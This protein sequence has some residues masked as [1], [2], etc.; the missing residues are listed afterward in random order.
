MDKISFDTE[1]SLLYKRAD[2][3][4]LPVE[5][6]IL[7]PRTRRDGNDAFGTTHTVIETLGEFITDNPD[8]N[9]SDLYKILVNVTPSSPEYLRNKLTRRLAQTYLQVRAPKTESYAKGAK[10]WT[11]DEDFINAVQDVVEFYYGM[12]PDELDLP[13]ADDDEDIFTK[14]DG[15]IVF[16]YPPTRDTLSGALL[17][18]KKLLD[19]IKPS[20][21]EMRGTRKIAEKIY[22]Y[23]SSIADQADIPFQRSPIYRKSE[24]VT[25]DVFLIEEDEKVEVDPIDGFLFF[26][27]SHLSENLPYLQY[28][29]M[30]RGSE[31][32]YYKVFRGES[33][34]KEPVY[35]NIIVS[36]D[37]KVSTRDVILMKVWF[38][39]PLSK[40]YEYMHLAPASA[41]VT[42]SLSLRDGTLSFEIPHVKNVENSMEKYIESVESDSEINDYGVRTISE[43]VILDAIYKAFPPGVLLENRREE[44]VKAEIMIYGADVDPTTLAYELS[45]NELFRQFLYIEE[46]THPQSLKTQLSV[47]Y[48]PYPIEEPLVPSAIKD[49]ELVTKRGLSAAIT[50]HYSKVGSAHE[51]YDPE[52][53]VT[54]RIPFLPLTPY[55]SLSIS[56]TSNIK[57]IEEFLSVFTLLLPIYMSNKP[58]IKAFYEDFLTKREYNSLFPKIRVEPKELQKKSVLIDLVDIIPEMA[59]KGY[60]RQAL[61]SH[62]PR[63]IVRDAIEEWV[64]Q[65][66]KYQ[67]KVY[68]KEVLPYPKPKSMGSGSIVLVEYKDDA[69]MARVLKDDG[70]IVWIPFKD[71]DI[72]YEEPS[73]WIVCPNNK[74]PFVGVKKNV[75]EKSMRQFPYMPHCYGLH[76]TSI[77]HKPS[78]SK[79]QK[80]Y[81]GYK[82]KKSK[83]KASNILKTN[84]ILKPGQKGRLASTD[85]EEILNQYPSKV[86]G[87]TFL[88]FG[89]PKSPNSLLHSVLTALV[90]PIYMSYESVEEKEEYVVK[91]RKHIASRVYPGLLKQEL[92]DRSLDEIFDV[93]CN[94]EAFLD[95]SVFYRAL[96]VVFN[97]NIYV[98]GYTSEKVDKKAGEGEM[99]I[100]RSKIYHTQPYRALPTILIVR[101]WGSATDVLEYPQSELIIEEIKGRKAT[102]VFSEEMGKINYDVMQQTASVMMWK[103]DTNNNLQIRKNLYDP[104]IE[105]Y[106][107]PDYNAIIGGN[108]KY[109]IIDDYGKMRGLIFDHDLSQRVTMLIEPSQP[110]NLPLTTK[111]RL[112]SCDDKNDDG[113]MYFPEE[114]EDFPLCDVDVA[115]DIFG[116]PISRTSTS[117]GMTSGLWFGEGVSVYV[118]INPTSEYSD[119]PIGDSNPFESGY[120]ISVMRLDKMKKDLDLVQQVL[121]WV[122]LNY[123]YPLEPSLEDEDKT[124][125]NFVESYLTSDEFDGDSA[126]YYNLDGIGRIFPEVDN[127][128]EALDS[129]EEQIK[130]HFEDNDIT[131]FHPLVSDG[132]MVFYNANFMQKIV[133]WLNEKVQR[134]SGL[135]D[136]KPEVVMKPLTIENYYTSSKDFQLQNFVTVFV[137]KDEFR[138]WLHTI[139]TSNQMHKIYRTITSQL[140]LSTEPFIYQDKKD[141]KIYY[142]QNV[143]GGSKERAMAAS[144]LWESSKRNSG[145]QTPPTNSK[146][147]HVIYGETIN[148]LVVLENNI[149]QNVEVHHK[150]PVIFSSVSKS[151]QY[152]RVLQYNIHET[153]K[154]A[155]MLELY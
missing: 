78:V 115:V 24:S 13:E 63:A 133:R 17:E 85:I 139:S 77:E 52:T 31:K 74:N 12:F 83:S 37:E 41:F 39:H 91:V 14:E 34:D 98:Y 26:N 111:E 9:A 140:A 96:E 128:E 136:T 3:L 15:K 119:I 131:D 124:F 94:G 44:G 99:V 145:W 35:K 51:V 59:K 152:L 100:P 50:Q 27:G 7:R 79:Y 76:G 43:W 154:Y 49:N 125:M 102:M 123:K 143:L 89:I 103:I 55:I 33:V 38:N 93:M 82:S 151:S 2:E 101:N 107:V 65:T 127:V 92:Y 8:V 54:K 22:E 75:S 142:I 97:I 71:V 109:Q 28:N 18:Y 70:E 147:P 132:K 60:T 6:F 16:R 72:D 121:W 104:D 90:D 25:Y 86:D 129:I 20:S 67:N 66:F 116:I 126:F 57:A 23:Q 141:D 36:P 5:L 10:G 29:T 21:P 137:G 32:N 120:D 114:V 84:K 150:I 68:H 155:A 45:F 4:G 130:E 106:T 47:R 134:V 105:D 56:R 149:D 146:Y 40:K 148:G 87:S 62:Q 73:A 42:V 118:P 95:P 11:K 81:L 46:S 58:A 153:P 135:E 64:S 1:L 144:K 138:K 117:D 61:K 88:R 108:G 19:L 110:I 30:K 80:Y 112:R 122:Y 48:A 69:V 113:E 53:R